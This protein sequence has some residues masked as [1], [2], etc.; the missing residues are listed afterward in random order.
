MP[1]HFALSEL[2]ICTAAILAAILLWRRGQ[3]QG[4]CGAALF[5]LAA[6]LGIVRILSG[7]PDLLVSAHRLASQAG[8]VLGVSLILAQ[9][10]TLKGV[11]W[12][13]WAAPAAAGAAAI[14]AGSVKG[15]GGPIFL[16]LLLA[17][18]GLLM[19]GPH[20]RRA[21]PRAAGLA[22]M[23]PNLIL[24]RQSPFLDPAMSWHAFHLVTALWL[25]V[26]PAAIAPAPDGQD[27][28]MRKA[29]C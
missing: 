7:G 15:A 16:I 25:L 21:W 28:A 17:G 23:A 11:R 22:L 8:G 5:G 19:T 3:K 1:A 20:R 13:Y 27:Q 4:A 24:L 26:L 9:I 29:A 2:A 10:L 14:L 12:P 18:A 6:G